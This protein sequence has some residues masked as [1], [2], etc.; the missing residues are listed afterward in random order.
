[1]F[2]GI[3]I[4]Q[5]RNWIKI[6]VGTYVERMMQKHLTTWMNDKYMLSKPTPLPSTQKI[7]R[8]FFNATG[9]PDEKEQARL[10]AAM[11]FTYR[12]GIRELIYPMR[13][14]RSHLRYGVV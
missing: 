12:S 13:T 11:G 14:S 3:D 2:N 4:Q 6:S 5:T 7:M 9:D 10:S 8:D 1:M